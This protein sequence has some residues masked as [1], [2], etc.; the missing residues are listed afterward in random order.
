MSCLTG[1]RCYIN[2]DIQHYKPI[3]K[4][5]YWQIPL[6][7]SRQSNFYCLSPPHTYVSQGSPLWLSQNQKQGTNWKLLW[8]LLSVSVSHP[9]HQ[10]LIL[11]SPRSKPKCLTEGLQNMHFVA[12][13]VSV[14]T[15]CFFHVNYSKTHSCKYVH[16]WLLMKTVLLTCDTPV[17]LPHFWMCGKGQVMCPIFLQLNWKKKKCNIYIIL[18]VCLICK[19]VL[20]SHVHV[21]NCIW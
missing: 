9:F 5:T 15:V 14:Y 11:L 13:F 21:A 1:P 2:T 18:Q 8:M 6:C 19:I 16:E 4:L 7:Q 20:N 10:D 17:R 3:H 12:R